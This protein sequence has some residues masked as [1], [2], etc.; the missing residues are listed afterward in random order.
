ELVL[1]ELRCPEV[2][3]SVGHELAPAATELVVENAGSGGPA[4]G[5]NGLARVGAG[6]GPAVTDH[7]RRPRRGCVELAHDA[8]PGLVTLPLHPSFTCGHAE[9]VLRG[10]SRADLL[11]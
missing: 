9:S 7:D 5:G 10:R 11:G 6:A 8:V 3:G 4:Q 2:G 1:E